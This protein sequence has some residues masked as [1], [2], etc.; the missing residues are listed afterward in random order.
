MGAFAPIARP[1]AFAA[2]PSLARSP[3]GTHGAFAGALCPSGPDSEVPAQAARPSA[4]SRAK[5][6]LTAGWCPGPEYPAEGNEG[7][8]GEFML[9]FMVEFMDGFTVRFMDIRSASERMGQ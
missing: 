1:G 6:S 4:S 2:F 8:T 9:G 3:L 5:A 7:F